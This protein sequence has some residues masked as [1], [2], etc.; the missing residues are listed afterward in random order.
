MSIGL[1]ERRGPWRFQV[2]PTLKAF[3]LWFLTASK[4]A[5]FPL[6]PSFFSPREYLLPMRSAWRLTGKRGMWMNEQINF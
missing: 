3:E 5:S 4:L 1:E 2:W 6:P